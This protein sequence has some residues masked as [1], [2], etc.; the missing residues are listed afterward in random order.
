VAHASRPEPPVGVERGGAA[1]ERVVYFSDAIFAIAI[2][3]QVIQIPVPPASEHQLGSALADLAPQF[4]SFA[5]SFLV[6]GQFWLAHHR[7]FRY[8]DRFDVSLLWLN[9]LL[10][11][12]VAFLPFPTALMGEHDNDR[13]AVVFYAMAMAATG[14]ASAAVWHYATF[15]RRC[16]DPRLEARRV[17]YLSRRSLVVPSLFLLTVPIAFLSTTLAKVLWLSPFPAMGIVRRLHRDVS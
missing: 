12:C 14:L 2:T 7:M 9:L 3:L 8:I 17:D 16:V 13:I 6:I 4:F 1:L 10:L 5:L 11:L 15:R